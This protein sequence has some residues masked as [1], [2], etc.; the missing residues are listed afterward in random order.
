LSYVSSVLS[1]TNKLKFALVTGGLPAGGSTTFLLNLA[2]GLQSF[3]ISSEVYSFTNENPLAVDFAAA[4]IPVHIA[5]ET[6]LIY[7]DRLANLY[8]AMAEF[9]PTVAIASLGIEAF[10]M[11]RYLP[12]GVTRL[13]MGHERG[14]LSSP[15]KYAGSLDAIVVVN[16]FWERLANELTP[17]VPSKYL[18]HGIPTTEADL[19][20]TP[21]PDRPL[22]LTYFGRLVFTKGTRLFP[23]IIKEL[24]QR[25][26]PF[27]WAIYG[28]GPDE[29][30]VRESLAAEIQAGNVTVSPHI[31]RDELF[32]TIR[33][34][35]VFIMASNHEGG[36]LTLLEAM[37]LGL[38]PICNDTPC[39]VQEVVT[40]N[41]GFIIPREPA[42]YAEMF[43]RLHKD[44]PL[45]ERMSIEARKTITEHYSITAMAERYIKFVKTMPPRPTAVSWPKKIKPRPIRGMPIL[46]RI[47][48]STGLVRQA[49]R[50]AKRFRN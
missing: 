10:E 39:L 27:R 25:S 3:G 6:K 33:Q 21:N 12:A 5:D 32:P 7:E 47:T 4:R 49:R 36:P 38:V 44:R 41:N 43:S 42:Q 40:P 2:T 14:M 13:A 50:L 19:T 9:Q 34:H 18:A 11:L 37:A 28:N 15:T 35:D 22:S 20:R 23:E 31:S 48:Q 16:P 26:V 1:M 8:H 45:L 17:G 46:S 29:G 24:H 30:Y